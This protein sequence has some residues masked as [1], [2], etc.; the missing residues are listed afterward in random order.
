MAAVLRIS[1][2]KYKVVTS[3]PS[4]IFPNQ[5]FWSFDVPLIRH[6]LR[7]ITEDQSVLPQFD[8][9]VGV[10]VGDVHIDVEESDLNECI[11]WNRTVRA[12]PDAFGV[13]ELATAPLDVG[14]VCIRPLL[15]V[16]RCECGQAVGM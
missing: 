10:H 13:P 5:R 7:L 3:G 15:H 14:E 1:A 2:R 11:T 9:E 12:D 8:R 6:S 16:A 4:S